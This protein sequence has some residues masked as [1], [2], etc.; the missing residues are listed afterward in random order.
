[1]ARIGLRV[2]GGGAGATAG[3]AGRAADPACFQEECLRAFEVSQVARGFS[4]QTIGN[5]AG[6]LDRFLA[7][8]GRPAWEV[9]QK[10][11][12]RVVA[13]FAAQGLAASTRRGYVQ[14]FKNFHAFLSVR[15]AAE[16]ET[17]FGLRLENPVDEFNAARH[18]SADSPAADPPPNGWRT[19]SGSCGS[20]SP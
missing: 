4:Q 9:T 17:A 20:G 5:A 18:V 19:F 6:T 8:C 11:V 15:K 10:D 13:G 16:I 1:M 14:A 2:V 12:D 7:A 3:L